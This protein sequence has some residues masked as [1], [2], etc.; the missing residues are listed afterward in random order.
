MAWLDCL[1]GVGDWL[2][3]GV[4]GCSGRRWDMRMCVC[5]CVCWTWDFGYERNSLSNQIKTTQIR[6]CPFLFPHWTPTVSQ[7][8][9]PP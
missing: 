5:V 2:D 6:T 3:S 9:N 4:D 7:T 1:W 8:K